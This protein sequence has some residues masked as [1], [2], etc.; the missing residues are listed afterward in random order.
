MSA[1]TYNTVD[2]Q[3]HNLIKYMYNLKKR[4]LFYFIKIWKKIGLLVQTAIQFYVR[5]YY[6][7]D[8]SIRLFG[9]RPQEQSS[10]NMLHTTQTQSRCTMGAGM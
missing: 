6:K 7:N 4:Y 8:K 5:H 3:G 1:T 10:G 9:E 2:F